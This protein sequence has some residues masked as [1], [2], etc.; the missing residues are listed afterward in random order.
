MWRSVC[1]V[2]V[3]T[4]SEGQRSAP[5][6]ACSVILRDSAL[7]VRRVKRGGSR[8]SGADERQVVLDQTPGAQES[9]TA[10]SVV[11]VGGYQVY[12]VPVSAR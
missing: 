1:G 6:A 9:F 7:R 12:S 5:W 2:I 4:V 10:V 11:R 8:R 3:L